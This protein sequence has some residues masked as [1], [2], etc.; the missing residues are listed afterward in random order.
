MREDSHGNWGGWLFVETENTLFYPIHGPVE[1]G[2]YVIDLE[3]FTSPAPMLDM[4]VQVAKKTW[5]SDACVAGLVWALQDLF[6][7]QETLCGNG[8]HLRMT[9]AQLRARISAAAVAKDVPRYEDVA[10]SA[11]EE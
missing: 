7:P 2:G 10:V 11:A 3:R 9:L 8:S 4:I 1:R 5:T 6:E